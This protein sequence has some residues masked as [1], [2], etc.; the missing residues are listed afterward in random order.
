MNF[1]DMVYYQVQKVP[2]GKV[3]SYGQIAAMCGNARAARQV[4]YALAGLGI[5]ERTVPWWRIVNSKGHISIRQGYGGLEKS[6]QADLLREEGI[7]IDE[8]MNI[9]LKKYLWSG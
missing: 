3:A 9:N 8:K 1:Y 4:G 2:T 5:D 7:E 6:I